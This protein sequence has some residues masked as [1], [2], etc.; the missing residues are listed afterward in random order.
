MGCTNDLA[1]FA[2]LHTW[3]TYTY[4]VELFQATTPSFLDVTVFTLHSREGMETFSR[5][6]V[7]CPVPHSLVPCFLSL[8]CERGRLSQ[9]RTMSGVELFQ[10]RPTV[11]WFSSQHA[12]S[13]RRK[14]R[15]FSI[16]R[17]SLPP[18]YMWPEMAFC[19]S[20]YV[21]LLPLEIRPVMPL[22][23]RSQKGWLQL[24]THHNTLFTGRGVGCCYS[25]VA[26]ARCGCTGHILIRNVGRGCAG[27]THPATKT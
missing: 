18:D 20:P 10:R 9:T 7:S 2:R 15:H 1:E 23:W 12:R 19:H 22:T 6:G 8:E 24:I 3:S 13:A 17:S 4:R 26:L 11:R 5:P 27:T 21:E 14:P 25:P 16:G